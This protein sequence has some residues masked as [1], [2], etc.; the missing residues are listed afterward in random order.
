MYVA[1]V[2][3]AD[4]IGRRGVRFKENT[5]GIRTPSGTPVEAKRRVRL[6][7]VEGSLPEPH[8]G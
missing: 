5:R 4:D 1:D 3:D 7:S 2:T 8:G 6:S